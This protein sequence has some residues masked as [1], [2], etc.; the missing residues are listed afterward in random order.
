MASYLSLHKLKHTPHSH[1]PGIVGFTLGTGAGIGAAWGLGAFYATHR[2]K[3]YGKYAPWIA[4]FAGKAV[5]IGGALSGHGN[6]A[7][8]GNDIGQSAA[9]VIA[10]QYGVKW[11]NKRKGVRAVVMS[12][13]DAAK[14]PAG[15]DMLGALSESTA[16]GM[17]RHAVDALYKSY[18]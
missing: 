14:L 11:A 16:R 8:V 10:A 5:A 9:A 7:T 6:V 3:W 4:A 2:D 17:D 1:R 12:E 18:T 13:A 15:S